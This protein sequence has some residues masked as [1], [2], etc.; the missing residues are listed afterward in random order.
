MTRLLLALCLCLQTMTVLAQGVAE[1]ADAFP[2]IEQLLKEKKF[3]DALA[4]VSTAV[5]EHPAS[6]QAHFLLG[7][8]HFY[9]EQDAPAKAAFTKAIERRPAFAEAYFFRGLVS[10]FGQ[11]FA[12]GGADFKR[13]TEFDAS[14]AKYWFELGRHHQRLEQDDAALPLFEKAV[15]LDPTMASGWFALGTIVS[16]KG[17]HERALAMWEKALAITPKHANTHYNLGQHHQL[18][19]DAKAAL[20]HFLAALEGRPNDIEIH[21]KVIQ[22]HYRLG[23]HAKAQPYRLKMF[24]LIAQSPDSAVRA[25]KEVCIDQFDAPGGRFFV[26]EAVAKDK[27]FFYWYTF[28]LTNQKG[29]IVKTINLEMNRQLGEPIMMLGQNEGNVH[30]NYGFGYKDLPAYASLKELVLKA[31]A[32]AFPAAATTRH[33]KDG[34]STTIELRVE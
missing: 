23:D 6:A 11:D 16:A 5:L 3:D 10:S 26:Y 7:K 19:G 9:R 22:A 12:Q 27:D 4:A 2:V 29:E 28:K 15:S 21:K 34:A 25:T 18:R 33:G 1:Q 17:D 14:K 30:T 31:H 13:A 8:T 20:G 24:A 32:G